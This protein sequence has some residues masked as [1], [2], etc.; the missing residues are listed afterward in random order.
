VVE[1]INVKPCSAFG[2]VGHYPVDHG[3]GTGDERFLNQTHT[4]VIKDP[5]AVPL[6]RGDNID[7][8]HWK[9]TSFILPLSPRDL[10]T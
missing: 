1:K 10:G 4:W 8:D 2:Y 3:V 9:E 7:R 5:H 6:V